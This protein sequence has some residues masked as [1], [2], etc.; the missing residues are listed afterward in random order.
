[1][2]YIKRQNSLN[3][4][5]DI[6]HLDHMYFSQ[7][8]IACQEFDSRAPTFRSSPVY[9]TAFPFIID[10]RLTLKIIGSVLF[11]ECGPFCVISRVLLLFFRQVT[12]FFYRFQFLLTTYQLCNDVMHLG[13]HFPYRRLE[14]ARCDYVVDLRR[15]LGSPYVLYCR[16]I[17]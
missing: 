3:L 11:D 14:P 16:I 13:L 10:S 1:M 17:I 9:A 15:G 6:D 2:I 8:Q 12:S 4:H 7:F 5:S